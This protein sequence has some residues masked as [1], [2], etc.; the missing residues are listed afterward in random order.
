MS[1]YRRANVCGGCYF[2][3]VV[4]ERRQPILIDEPVRVHYANN[5]YNPSTQKRALILCFYFALCTAEILTRGLRDFATNPPYGTSF[6]RNFY[7]AVSA[8]AC[9]WWLLFFYGR[10][11]AAANYFD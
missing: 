1:R 11:R 4:T 2:F 6:K 3:T 8:G 9:V 10:Y 7:V 5:L